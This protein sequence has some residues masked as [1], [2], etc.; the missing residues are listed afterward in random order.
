MNLKKII[1]QGIFLGLI[2]SFLSYFITNSG[3]NIYGHY[4]VIL[5]DASTG[6]SVVAFRGFPFSFMSTSAVATMFG[7][8]AFLVD[9]IIYVLV[10]IAIGTIYNKYK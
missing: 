9:F 7:Y 6:P 3:I 10:V 4:F 5:V 2:L 1:I 8:F